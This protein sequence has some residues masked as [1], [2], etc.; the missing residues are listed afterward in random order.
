MTAAVITTTA[1]L[2]PVHPRHSL[3]QLRKLQAFVQRLIDD[4]RASWEEA[5]KRA[6]KL[7]GKFG[8]APFQER[9]P[10]TTVF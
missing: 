1:E 3:D 6:K 8:N 2:A 5:D 10:V 7:L 9:N 4:P